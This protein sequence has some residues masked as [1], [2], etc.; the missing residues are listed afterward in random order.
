MPSKSKILETTIQSQ[1]IS[2]LTIYEN[3]GKL[4]F[5]RSAS[6]QVPVKTKDGANRFFKTGKPGCPDLTIIFPGSIEVGMEVKTDDGELSEVQKRTRDYFLERGMF[7]VVVRSLQETKPIIEL[8]LD[9]TEKMKKSL[10]PLN[11]ALQAKLPIK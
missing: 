4:Y 11:Q 2:L 6:G 10:I 8:F 9:Y 1:I 7:Y 5:Y 3:Q